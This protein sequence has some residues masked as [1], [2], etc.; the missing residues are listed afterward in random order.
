MFYYI[1]K[2]SSENKV[3]IEQLKKDI[4][5]R[6]K[7]QPVSYRWI[8]DCLSKGQFFDIAKSQSFIYKPFN[9]KTPI[10]GFHKMVFDTL[11]VDDN[12]KIRLK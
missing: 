10:L 6:V 12:L 9:F 11:G 4:K 8:N 3:L 7:F 2:D 5:D 1:L